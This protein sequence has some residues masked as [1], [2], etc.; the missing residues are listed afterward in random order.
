MVF[1]CIVVLSMSVVMGRI[2][3]VFDEVKAVEATDP[4][5]LA[6]ALFTLSED[7]IEGMSQ[8]PQLHELEARV[9]EGDPTQL[10]CAALR[11]RARRSADRC[12]P[13]GATQVAERAARARREVTI[14]PGDCTGMTRLVADLPTPMAMQLWSA[15]DGLAAEYARARPGLPMVAARADAL[16]DLVAANATITTTKDASTARP[17]AAEPWTPSPWACDGSSGR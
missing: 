15:V 10:S 2:E 4:A 1:A 7:E 5:V 9:L 17:S 13:Q 11:K 16:A 6:R 3:H 12:N 14:R 8:D